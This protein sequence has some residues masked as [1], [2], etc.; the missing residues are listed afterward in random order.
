M[1]PEDD[2]EG[3]GEGA[4]GGAGEP[5]DR[6][7]EGGAGAGAGDEAGE[8]EPTGFLSSWSERRFETIATL[9]L[10]IAALATTWAGY[11]ASL[12]GGIQSS[13]YS[14]AGALRVKSAQAYTRA[15]QLRLAD[16][17]TFQ[18]FLDAYGA[19]NTELSTFYQER[20]RPEFATAFDAWIALTPRTNPDAPASPFAMPEYQLSADA[21]GA[22][23]SAQA[24]AQFNAGEDAN[25]TSD[26]YVLA[27]LL[28][29]S[30]LF[31]A[32]ISERIETPVL[33][34]SLLG[35]ALLA[36]TIGAIVTATQRVTTGA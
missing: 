25:T 19:G 11:Q 23:L 26:T 16:L 24:E 14:Q 12:W 3:A 31:F 13:H 15:D 7:D 18:G 20:F 30:V 21:D 17:S 9:L 2:V 33:R 32:G 5:A 28:F 35:I 27:T 4:G 8:P 36:L 10:A 1:D 34:G 29:A 6:G 22:D